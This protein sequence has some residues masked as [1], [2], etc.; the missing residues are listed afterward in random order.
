MSE[1]RPRRPLEALAAIT[2]IGCRLPG[3]VHDPAALWDALTEGALLPR[4]IPPQ[5]WERMAALLHPDQRPDEPWIAGVIDDIDAFDHSYFGIPA[6]E[7]AQMDPQQRMV[8][9]VVVE[10][11][12]DA[13]LSPAAL[14]GSTRVGVWVGSA[15]FDQAALNFAA[16]RRV[17]MHTVS[18]TSPSILANRVSYTL[19]LRGPSLAVD[20]ACSASGTALHLARQSVESAEVDTAIVIGANIL[21]NPGP[22]AAFHD[23]G[24]LAPDGVC[25]PFD[26]HGEG[27]VRAEGVV[28]LVL[29]RTEEAQRHHDRVYAVLRGSVAN[30]DGR[31]PGLYAP[32]RDAHTALLTD[33]YASAGMDPSHVDYVVC[34]GTGTKAGDSSEGRALARVLAAGRDEPLTIGSI[35]STLGH[36][37]GA[38][39]LLGVAA[40]ALA[41]HHATVPP[42]AAH[43]TI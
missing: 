35:K 40:A 14:A 17:D 7:A 34:H 32:N 39:G 12:A 30:S 29:R 43:E 18:G 23:A 41:L 21:L 25:R 20:T 33:A 22:T 9:E 31:S 13:G 5:R 4:P 26:E 28:A 42:T 24:V 11:L 3:G 10:A 38:S 37:E 36:T 8:M 16:G 2:G 1:K 6:G 15:S 19:D 27:Y